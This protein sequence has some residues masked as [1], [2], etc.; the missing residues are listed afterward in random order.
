MQHVRHLTLYEKLSKSSSLEFKSAS[1]TQNT[2]GLYIDNSSLTSSR[3]CKSPLAFHCNMEHPL[4]QVFLKVFCVEWWCYFGFGTVTWGFFFLFCVPQ[5]G[6]ACFSASLARH[7]CVNLYLLL[8]GN[9]GHEAPRFLHRS[10]ATVGAGRVVHCVW[11]RWAPPA[12]VT[13]PSCLIIVAK[14][15]LWGNASHLLASENVIL[16]AIISCR[17][18]MTVKWLDVPPHSSRSVIQHYSYQMD[19]R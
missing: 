10:A 18:D 6:C 14:L 17:L 9:G 2:L 8:R 12:I 5:A 15:W 4:W 19:D 1:W 7:T 16:R 3:L 11:P 13:R